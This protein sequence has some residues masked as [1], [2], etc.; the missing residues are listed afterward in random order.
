MTRLLSVRIAIGGVEAIRL[1][2]GKL[3]VIFTGIFMGPLAGGLVGGIS[4]L[5]GY[6]INPM[7]AYMP[8]FTVGA[9]LT[10]I[11]PG[12]V[13]FIGSRDPLRASTISLVIA[14]SLPMVFITVL[15]TPYFL[16]SLF[17]ISR[18]VTVPPRIIETI[19]TVAVYTFLLVYLRNV[20]AIRQLF[21][22]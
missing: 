2:L 5:I 16:E 13:F 19:I 8:H 1:G 12:L 6:M 4:D 20:S 3:P 18:A 7:G 17:G 14:V 15:Y 22:D 21:T 9:A 11:L 10:G